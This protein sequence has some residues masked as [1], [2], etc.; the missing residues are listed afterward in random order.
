M[1]TRLSKTTT[2]RGVG[3]AKRHMVR[4]QQQPLKR[5]TAPVKLM[6]TFVM[7]FRTTRRRRNPTPSPPLG[8][9]PPFRSWSRFADTGFAPPSMLAVPDRSGTLDSLAGPRSPGVES[10]TSRQSSS[11]YASSFLDYYAHEEG[12]TDNEGPFNLS[13]GSTFDPRGDA[14]IRFSLADSAD[15]QPASARVS[16]APSGEVVWQVLDDLRTNRFSIASQ[17]SSLGFGSRDSSNGADDPALV[18]QLAPVATLLRYVSS[19]S[20]TN[21]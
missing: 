4:T 12:E 15:A 6:L 2:T 13:T 21:P 10:T 1:E 19:C 18:D 20:G 9:L 17:G 16:G 3:I 5:T 7:R 8:Q 14:S 11:G